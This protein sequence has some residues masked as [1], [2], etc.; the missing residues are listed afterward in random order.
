[1]WKILFEL[2][3]LAANRRKTQIE[4]ATCERMTQTHVE[5][6]LFVAIEQQIFLYLCL[7]THSYTQKHTHTEFKLQIGIFFQLNS[8]HQIAK[9]KNEMKWYWK[10]NENLC[11][12]IRLKLIF[13]VNFDVRAL[14]NFEFNF[15]METFTQNVQNKMLTGLCCSL[16][17]SPYNKL[18]LLG[19]LFSSS[20]FK[21]IYDW[22]RWELCLIRFRCA[23]VFV[24]FYAYWLLLLLLFSIH[25]FDD[26]LYV[27]RLFVLR[28]V[29]LLFSFFV[30]FVSVF[31]LS[32]ESSSPRWITIDH[33][34]SLK[35]ISNSTVS[36]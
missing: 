35:M 33:T 31:F 10:L 28:F 2:T 12:R 14:G 36:T 6:W 19:D 34:C 15:P 9:R 25:L 7:D 30:C 32:L 4:I 17:A 24:T 1:M 11:F 21:I 27:R 29:V 3:F 22:S 8:T 20:V 23:L 5:N 16:T 13:G 26:W 18:R